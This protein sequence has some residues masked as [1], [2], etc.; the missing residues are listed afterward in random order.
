ME[1][2]KSP[3]PRSLGKQFV[4]TVIGILAGLWLAFGTGAYLYP[5]ENP[6]NLLLIGAIVGMVLITVVAVVICAFIK[7]LN[8]LHDDE[9]ED[10]EKY[11]PSY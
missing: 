2:K 7:I 5:K 4:L 11:E 9:E 8:F 10:L 6:I 3:K 1:T